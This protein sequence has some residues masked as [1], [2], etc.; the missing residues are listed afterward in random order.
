MPAMRTAVTC[1]CLAAGGLVLAAWAGGLTGPTA[2]PPTRPSLPAH[3][4]EIFRSHCLACHGGAKTKK[5]VRIL[6][7]EL[8]V[9][10]TKVV[11]PSRPD[12]SI[13]YRLIT[14]E[15]EPVM[16][17]SGQPRLSA[18]DIDAIRQ[19]IAAGAPA[20]PADVPPPPEPAKDKGLQ[21]VV[22]VDYAHKRILAHVRTLD[23]AVRRHVR[24]FSINHLLTGGATRAELDLHRAALAK[25]INHLSWQRRLIKPQAIDPL[26]TIFC[27]DLRDLGWDATPFDRLRG[28]E[29]IGRSDLNL[30]DLVLLEY[31]Y[32]V[33]HTESATFA[34]L[35]REFLEPAAQVRPIV[36]V[37]ADW[38]V[39]VA[40]Q[41]PLYEDL[42]QLPRD[43]NSLEK[44]L[45]VEADDPEQ[46]RTL[47]AGLT[48]SGE[49]PS[50]RVLERRPSR[51][52]VFWRTYD[53]HSSKGQENI[54]K[55]P[56]RLQPA[57]SEILF[58]LPNGLNGYFLADGLG[59]RIA[60][61]PAD[62]VTDR[63]AQD[64]AMRNGLACMRCH[65]Q[66]VKRF[67]DTMRPALQQLPGE[68]GFD[69]KQALRLYAGQADLDPLLAKDAARYQEALTA[70]LGKAPQEPLTPVAH[71]FLDGPLQLSGAGAE[72]G[73]PG[74]NKLREVF[75]RPKFAGLGLLPLAAD[76]A[77]RRDL[78]EDYYDQVVR[79]L[80]IGVPV[81][82]LDALTRR[83]YQP[84][85]PPFALELLTDKKNNIFAPGDELSIF[86]VN[87]SN[88]DLYI[89]LIGTSTKGRQ[90]LL[91]PSSTLLKAGQ[92]FRHPPAGEVLK[93]RSG[94]GKE[95]I[96]VLASEQAFP[97]G[98]LLRGR[99]AEGRSVADRVVHPFYALK[100]EE[101]RTVVTFDPAKMLKKTIEIET[102]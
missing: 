3:V 69:R 24:F 5:N 93:I 53:Y 9:R 100:R 80:G 47:R 101:G 79:Q 38:F 37:R 31:P 72:L 42:L 13:L 88:R 83:A 29:V 25:A 43:L 52:G 2:P 78:W 50:N 44:R 87:K 77:V 16:P 20:F 49:S 56:L 61:A 34:E 97:E 33:V 12:D 63:F 32:G 28:K 86:V 57:G 76:G 36:H 22:G 81:A 74:P 21:D 54:F 89:E 99:K 90:I 85:P 91:A 73:L 30:F 11:I 75:A 59:D 98:E 27:V 95:Q 94:L 7:R 41:P 39:S 6:D 48:V 40:T 58:S 64:R 45:G 102:R 55:D 14:A 4:K 23:R 70:L 10:E 84:Q 1:L 96:T 60:A 62:V 65:D 18:A 71:R 68:A 17:P 15:D 51:N 26:D 19:W 92:T 46:G 35:V 82:P 8:L 67:T 66:G